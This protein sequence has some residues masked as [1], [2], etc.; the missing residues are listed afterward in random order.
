MGLFGRRRDPWE[1][2]GSPKTFDEVLR[3]VVMERLAR[4]S[5]QAEE[6]ISETVS[7]K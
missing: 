3:E 7:D 1:R 5:A 6:G 4:E 2:A